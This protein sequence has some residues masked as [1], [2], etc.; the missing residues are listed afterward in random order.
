MA[1]KLERLEAWLREA[2]DFDIDVIIVHDFRENR[3]Q[4]ELET[5][6]KNIQSD[7]FKIISG[8]FGSPGAAR[9]AGLRLVNSEWVGF[10]DSDDLPEVRNAFEEILVSDESVDVIVGQFSLVDL[11]DRENQG[12]TSSTHSLDSLAVNPG[13]WR[14]LFRYTTVEKIEFPE[15]RMGEDQIFLNRL[16]LGKLQIKFS[17]KVFYHYFTGVT[18]QLT[19]NRIAINDLRETINELKASLPLKE[20]SD[21]RF[22]STLLLRN[23]STALIQGK[24]QLK[25][26]TLAQLIETF[27]GLGLRTTLVLI[28]RILNES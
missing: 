16:N 13:L 19:S 21:L 4:V 10:W 8:Q 26:Q 15:T 28:N 9:N 12:K 18:G 23:L 20:D 11:N 3:T 1:G 17:N 5:I 22:T 7:K 27:F 24:L 25:I 14:I 2:L 6:L